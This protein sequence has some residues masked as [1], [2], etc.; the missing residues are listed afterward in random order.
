M[1][2]SLTY[3]SKQFFWLLIKL[4]IVFGCAFFIYQKLVFNNDINFSFFKNE[5]IQKNIFTV[6]NLCILLFFSVFNWVL[7]ILKWQNLVNII[8]NISFKIAT[9]QCLA[10][11]T[12]SLITPN[13][14]GEYGAKSMYFKKPLRK[15][16]LGFNF[17]GNFYQ[18]IA[19]L[20]FGSIGFSF[21]V[22]KYPVKINFNSVF[23]ILII[24]FLAFSIIYLLIKSFQ[25]G[26]SYL[27]RIKNFI[28]K[29]SFSLNLK[30]LSL[31]FLRYLVF[32]HQFYFLLV[33]FGIEIPYL[34]TIA[35]IT[36]IYLIASIVPML[37]FFDIVLKS[38]VA[39]W[40]FS[41]LKVD[42]LIV[43]NAV[44]L[45]W[46]LNFAIP[47]VIGSY[48]VLTFKPNFTK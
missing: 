38:T 32:S 34:D 7:E 23:G 26:A 33:L 22:S 4:T 10:S 15:Q 43:L 11:L 28:Q 1:Q 24:I 48:F 3:K 5:L 42:I 9:T 35:A 2:I 45:I 17:I 41:F 20:F 47:A 25:T 12:T 29:I 18:L 27:Q 37:S 8:Q 14:I 36:S 30:I 31:S 13:R 16:I 6:K 46:I 21:F 19:T 40:V 39:I 44:T